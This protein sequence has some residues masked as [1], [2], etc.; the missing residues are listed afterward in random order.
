MMDALKNEFPQ[1]ASLNYVVN[2]KLNDTIFDLDIVNYCGNPYI[3]ESLGPL[4]YKIGQKSFF[5]TNTLQ[6]ENLFNTVISF[7]E[8]RKEDNV[9]DLYCG[10]G[11]KYQ[12]EEFKVRYDD[13]VKKHGKAD[14]VITDPPRAG[15]HED[16]IDTLLQLEVPKIV[17]ISCN[18]ASQARDLALLSKKYDV[19]AIQPVDMFPHTHHIESVAKLSLKT[20]I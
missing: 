6:A 13:F 19:L 8:F 4:K 2:T 11:A 17:Y 14:V 1:I 16:V 12:Y 15:M 18:P 5:Q 20:D 7:G 9:L 10:C 3:I